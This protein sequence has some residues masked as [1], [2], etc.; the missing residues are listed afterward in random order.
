VAAPAP[1]GG[2]DSRS[3]HLVRGMGGDVFW[4]TLTTGITALLGLASLAFATHAVGLHRLGVYAIADAVAVLAQTCSVTSAGALVRLAARERLGDP[5]ARAE[6]LGIASACRWIAVVIPIGAVAVSPLLG[7][8]MHQHGADLSR[9]VTTQA[10][11]AVAA[12]IVMAT[13]GEE[14]V[15]IGR[16]RF[17]RL[18]GCDVAG[19]AV[20]LAL[21]I[22][23]APGIGIV[24]LAIARVAASIVDRGPLRVLTRRECPWFATRAVSQWTWRMATRRLVALSG[25]LIAIGLTMQLVTLTDNLVVG[26]LVGLGAVGAY[27]IAVALPTQAAALIF[28]GYDVVLPQLAAS[29]ATNAQLD[30][31]RFL[32]RVSCFV[33]GAVLVAMAWEAGPLVR[34]LSGSHSSLAVHVLAL[35]AAVWMVNLSVHGYVIFLVARQQQSLVTRLVVVEAVGNAALTIGFVL[36]FGAIGAAIATLVAVVVSNALVLP[37][38][39]ARVTSIRAWDIS[40][41]GLIAGLLGGAAASLVAVAVVVVPSAARAPVD[42]FATV[43]VTAVVGL[44]LLGT[45]GRSRLRH[46]LVG[47]SS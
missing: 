35:F 5:A 14:A 6:L 29:S 23:L 31:T 38:M 44:I 17:R 41:R 46:T 24:G 34:V 26:G 13:T 33:G 21:V 28:R 4:A 15:S 9:F 43:V 16:R 11:L 40:G 32:T 12:T 22:V 2:D 3:G 1:T 39:L 8:L 45:S 19:G 42:A 10:I 25:P 36:W 27:R 47:S 30:A 7:L 37:R 20:N 18:C